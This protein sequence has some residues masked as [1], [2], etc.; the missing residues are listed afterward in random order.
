MLHCVLMVLAYSMYWIEITNISTVYG[1]CVKIM[2]V[3]IVS[4]G[5]TLQFSCSHF[6]TCHDVTNTC[7]EYF[8][9]GH[10]VV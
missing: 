8:W 10:V 4:I 2:F 6:R 1:Q 5:I 7:K 9:A 3:F